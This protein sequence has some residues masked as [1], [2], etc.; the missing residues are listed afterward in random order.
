MVVL[1]RLSNIRK[2]WN[3]R[4]VVEFNLFPMADVYK[5]DKKQ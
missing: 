5:I 4:T 1:N 2:H 3:L